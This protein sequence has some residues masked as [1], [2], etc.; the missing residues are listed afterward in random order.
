MFR[1]LSGLYQTVISG[2]SVIKTPSLHKITT[3]EKTTV[4]FKNLTDDEIFYYISTG[5][6]MDKAGAYAIQG[7]GSLIVERIDGCYFNVMGL[8][9]YRLSKV[10]EDF[11]YKL[12]AK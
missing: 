10:L 6:P 5:E 7:I 11:E 8:P 3:F 9:V 12:L 4:K 2:I 1:S